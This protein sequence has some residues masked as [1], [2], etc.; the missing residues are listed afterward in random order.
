[1]AELGGLSAT[2][3]IRTPQQVDQS[4]TEE[5]HPNY[6]RVVTVDPA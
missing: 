2:L 3:M 1:M 4:R 6:M 5:A